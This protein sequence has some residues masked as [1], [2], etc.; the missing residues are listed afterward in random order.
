MKTQQQMEEEYERC[1]HN[2]FDIYNLSY[3][4]DHPEWVRYITLMW[5]LD[6][7]VMNKKIKKELI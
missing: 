6:I 4:P 1:R 2:I 5:V 3:K 7:K